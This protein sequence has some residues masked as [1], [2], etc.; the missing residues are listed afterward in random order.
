MKKDCMSFRQI[1]NFL[2]HRL[3]EGQEQQLR[4]HL[5]D[6]RSCQNEVAWVRQVLAAMGKQAL[7][8]ESSQPTESEQQHFDDLVIKYHDGSLTIEERDRLY[9]YLITSDFLLEQF[10]ATSRAVEMDMPGEEI[11]AD[12]PLDFKAVAARLQQYDASAAKQG[13]SRVL[14]PTELLQRARGFLRLQFSDLSRAFSFLAG[15]LALAVFA[16]FVIGTLQDILALGEYRAILSEHRVG[17][18]S[19]IPTDANMHEI[20]SLRESPAEENPATSASEEDALSYLPG[21]LQKNPEDARLNHHMANI[22]LIEGKI[23]EAE[24]MFNTALSLDGYDAEALNGLAIIAFERKQYGEAIDYLQR[25][26]QLKPDFTEAFYN[27]AIAFQR[28]KQ[29]EAA[30]E[31]WQRFLNDLNLSKESKIAQAARIHLSELQN[32]T[33]RPQ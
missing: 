4:A 32:E 7:S 6:C 17:P 15:C 3:D 14:Q 13:R 11:S 16:F 5:S 9:T 18:G 19:M 10:M 20:G 23:A 27:L 1:Y 2:N 31:T 26:L 25:A 22:F 12:I 30:I 24:A 21:A 28:S 33:S 29:K 8:A